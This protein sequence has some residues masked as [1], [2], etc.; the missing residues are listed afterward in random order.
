MTDAIRIIA[1]SEGIPETATPSLLLRAVAVRRDRKRWEDISLAIV[2]ANMVL[3][4]FSDRP[5][6]PLDKIK[7]MFTD[8]EFEDMMVQ[9][10]EAEMRMLEEQQMAKLRRMMEWKTH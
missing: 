3:G 10:E 4:G 7:V 9:R 5:Q 1:L 6:D 2:I 8:E